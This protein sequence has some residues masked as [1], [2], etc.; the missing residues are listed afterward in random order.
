MPS[1][2][3]VTV[4]AYRIPGVVR[5]SHAS[6]EY[7]LPLLTAARIAYRAA[8]AYPDLIAP[9]DEGRYGGGPILR[10]VAVSG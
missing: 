4:G 10:D 5:F 6:D 1:C 8:N 7:T 3:R 9:D 2:D